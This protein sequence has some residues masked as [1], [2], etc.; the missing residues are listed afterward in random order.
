MQI[1]RRGA[2]RAERIVVEHSPK[3]LDAIMAA[4]EMP[5]SKR[6]QVD[7]GWA[8]VGKRI[9]ADRKAKGISQ[10]ELG[11]MLGFQVTTSMWRYEDGRCAIPAPR[12]EQI[13]EI[14][15]MPPER[16]LPKSATKK[17]QAELSAAELQKLHQ[18]IARA[19]M[20]AAM[21]GTP[22]A[23]ENLNII[24]AEHHKRTGR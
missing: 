17:Q 14:L 24:I 3:G 2:R 9:A 10:A 15:G 19:A 13:A 20:D 22:E 18:R 11:R 4:P 16:Y 1:A 23:I 5:K 6:D 12:L 21:M 7:P 8:V